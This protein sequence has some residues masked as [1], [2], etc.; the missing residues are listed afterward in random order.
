MSVSFA[1]RLSHP[2]SRDLCTPW[3]APYIEVLTCVIYNCEWTARLECRED[4]R[5][6]RV[7]QLNAQT[8]DINGFSLLRQWS[9][10]ICQH[11][12]VNETTDGLLDCTAVLYICAVLY[13]IDICMTMSLLQ[14]FVV[15]DLYRLT[16]LIHHWHCCICSYCLNIISSGSPPVQ[17]FQLKEATQW[18]LNIVLHYLL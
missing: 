7:G 8:H 10:S 17:C 9:S 2:G 1:P 11:A 12:C 14:L 4:C 5:R 13:I 16:M 18:F 15:V 3:N 6:G